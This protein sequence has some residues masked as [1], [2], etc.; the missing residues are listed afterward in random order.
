MC[1]CTAHRTASYNY[2]LQPEC[3]IRT[4][5]TTHNQPASQEEKTPIRGRLRLA[6]S[7]RLSH[8][9]YLGS[10]SSLERR[11]LEVWLP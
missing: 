9:S 6:Q 10:N 11:E 4:D 3:R 8:I 1:V 7:P 5:I 2:N